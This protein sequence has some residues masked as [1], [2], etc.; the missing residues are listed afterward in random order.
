MP[1]TLS[2][3]IQL[4][5]TFL[6]LKL[7]VEERH[8]GFPWGITEG[9]AGVEV[10]GSDLDSACNFSAVTLEEVNTNQWEIS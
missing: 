1:V 6:T 10:E 7:K 9:Q 3:S 4:R 5:Q 2:W 8:Y